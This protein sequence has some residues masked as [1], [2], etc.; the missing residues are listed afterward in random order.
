MQ[1]KFNSNLIK[2]NDDGRSCCVPTRSSYED[3]LGQLG[4]FNL[5]KIAAFPY[6]KEGCKKET[7]QEPVVTEQGG[8]DSS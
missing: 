1:K 6:L 3:R 4:L 5:K 7:L 2:E 8:M